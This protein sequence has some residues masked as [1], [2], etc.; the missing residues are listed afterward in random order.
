MRKNNN[1]YE[2]NF[3]HS[4]PN[5]N[6]K[7]EIKLDFIDIKLHNKS[8]IVNLANN[9]KYYLIEEIIFNNIDFKVFSY[10]IA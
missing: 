3:F 4:K 2:N 6:L 9:S 5:P 8:L 10:S 7:Y 1:N